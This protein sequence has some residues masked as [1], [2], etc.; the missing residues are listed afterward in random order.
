MRRV[1]ALVVKPGPVW[2]ML[3]TD[4]VEV[5]TTPLEWLRET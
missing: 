3:L 1:L 2:H 5:F 4:K